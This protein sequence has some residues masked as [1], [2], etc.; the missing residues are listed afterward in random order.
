MYRFRYRTMVKRPVLLT[1]LPILLF[2]GQT[3][4]IQ[5]LFCKMF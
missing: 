1:H 5:E 3:H 4:R 2:L